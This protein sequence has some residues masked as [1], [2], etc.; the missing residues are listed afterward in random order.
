VAGEVTQL[1]ASPVDNQLA[2]GH[3]DGTI[4]LWN[5][6]TGDCECTLSGHRT[7]VTALRFAASGATLASGSKDTDIILWDV[8]AEAGLF[9]LRGHSGQ[10][11]DLAFIGTTCLASSSKD[12]TLRVWDL[13]AQHC[14]QTVVSHGGEVWSLDVDP[15]GERLA[16]G[17]ADTELRVF[18]IDVAGVDTG[19][20]LKPMGWVR[21]ST[22]ERAGMVRY[23]PDPAGTLLMCQAAGKVTDVW[24]VRSE[25]EAAKKLKRRRKRRKEKAGQ[26]EPVE[27]P[28]WEVEDL[29]A[30]EG[31]AV[32]EEELAASDELE[33]IA[34]VRCKHKVRS[35]AFAPGVASSRK[36]HA[37]R[38][39]L[40]LANNSIE[41]WDVAPPAAPHL[42]GQALSA[43]DRS[44][45]VDGAG[46]R[47][48]VRA[49]ALS[50]DDALC[51]SVS[52]GCVKV[53]NPATGAC[54]RTMEAG[55][56]LC[57][58]FAPGNKHVVVGTKEGRVEV[59]D[60]GAAE[61]VASIE[62][63]EGAIW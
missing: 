17:A 39:V 12:E 28:V 34:A 43:G 36:P 31:G 44:A 14:C 55:Y 2:V 8:A 61:R 59:F 6:D 20:V 37:A 5:L 10:V 3:A 53:W 7:A 33:A 27:R 38:L 11:T 13:E 40:A 29:E 30:G 23:L 45:F 18:G 57:A 46:H 19:A 62:A 24:R 22:G 58:L 52:A 26:K 51:A 42:E 4:R 47:S 21:R 56:G 16:V 41:V 1:A 32:E 49:L 63:H 48:D 35:A 60:V 15:A 25:G 50:S 9:R 54:M